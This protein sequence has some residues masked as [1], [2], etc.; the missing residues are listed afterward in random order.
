MTIASDINTALGNINTQM[1]TLMS[2]VSDV[3]TGL[4][5]YLPPSY[6][7]ATLPTLTAVDAT[8]TAGAAVNHALGTVTITVPGVYTTTALDTTDPTTGIAFTPDPL[9]GTALS[10]YSYTLSDATLLAARNEIFTNIAGFRT[11]LEAASIGTLVSYD[12]DVA[13]NKT[14]LWSENFWTDL[15]T[16]LSAFTDN[17]LNTDNVDTVITKLSA[18]ATKMESALYRKGQQRKQQVLRDRLSAAS[19]MA[20]AK[21]FTYPNHH[22]FGAMISASQDYS[23]SLSEEADKLI[24][25]MTEW[26]KSNYKFAL[27]KRISSHESDVAFNNRFIDTCLQ[28]VT[29]KNRTILE[30]FKEETKFF[31]S[32]IETEYRLFD[33]YLKE[34]QTA[35]ESKK[36]IRDDSL[37]RLKYANE[38]EGRTQDAKHIARSDQ[39][40]RNRI[41]VAQNTQG[42]EQQADVNRQ[43]AATN[44]LNLETAK[45]TVEQTARNTEA[46]QRN[47]EANIQMKRLGNDSV[48]A[49]NQIA[50]AAYTQRVN[51]N[52]AA[53]NTAFAAKLRAH[54]SN[55]DA[56]NETG[57]SIASMAASSAQAVFNIVT[58][59]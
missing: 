38:V 31:L 7:Y 5:S 27:E 14:A 54:Q 23:F 33:T 45:I 21:G 46:T 43:I 20:G 48:I 12:A 28:A 15:K 4:G 58:T 44:A 9:A 8:V 19:S 51:E 22:N 59:A 56:I 37:N 41:T 6:T 55:I 35:N 57:R 16:K 32:E 3:T 36:L 53:I 24:G 49:N 52:M 47:Y 13:G 30:K 42:I 26:A 17:I 29:E 50:L 39:Q 34:V 10:Q 1:T 25:I 11:S 18:D 40:E 2:K